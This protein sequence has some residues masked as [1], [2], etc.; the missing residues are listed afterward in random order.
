[1]TKL[2]ASDGAASDYFG[3]SVAIDGDTLVVGARYDDDNGSASGSVYVFIHSGIIWTQQ[4]KLTASDG[5]ADDRFGSSVAIDGDTIVVGA[6]LNDD[7][8]TD[9]GTAY[10]FTRSGTTWTQQAK[11]T[12]SDGA[13]DDEFGQSVAIAGD[14]IVVGA[15]RD[16]DNGNRQWIAYVFTRSG[17][18]WT[19]ASQTDSQRW[20]C[21]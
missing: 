10:V 13:L 17:T 2:T 5:A 20:C 1:M 16:D 8:G 11:L 19:G 6:L 7:N 9:S 12:A 14:T 4:A 3:D 15:D 18:A 21:G